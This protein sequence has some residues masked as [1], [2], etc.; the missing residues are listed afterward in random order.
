MEQRQ[1]YCPV[2]CFSI[3]NLFDIELNRTHQLS[4]DRAQHISQKKIIEGP[5]ISLL[6]LKG[7]KGIDKLRQYMLVLTIC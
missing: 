4:Y 6:I 5:K 1:T 7:L 2:V 3:Y